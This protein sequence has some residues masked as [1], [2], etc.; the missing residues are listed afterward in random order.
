VNL[1]WAELM[2]EGIVDPPMDFDL[3]RQDPKNPPPAPWTLQPSHP[4]LLEELAQEFEKSGYDLRWLFTTITKSK[5]YQLSMEFDGEW[6]PRYERHFARRK[7]RRLSAQQ[8]FDG[9]ADLTGVYREIPVRYDYRKVGTIMETRSPMDLDRNAGNKDLHEA[10]SE[11]GMCD[12]YTREATREIGMGQ[13][14][15]LLNDEVV[16]NWVK[17][18]EKGRLADLLRSKDPAPDDKVVEELFLAAV[19]RRP[20]TDERSAALAHL[21]ADRETG[22]EDLVWALTNSLEFLFY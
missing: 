13:T 15:I 3:A 14:A 21:T 6:L 9:I 2:G 12:R 20:S 5:T 19:A 8:L 17:V 1:F 7:A 11:F 16:R 4:E 18:G 22:A 10:A